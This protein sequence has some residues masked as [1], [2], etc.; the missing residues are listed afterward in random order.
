MLVPVLQR[1]EGHRLE[2]SWSLNGFFVSF[3]FAT[4]WTEHIAENIL[5]LLKSHTQLQRFSFSNINV[6]NCKINSVT[7]LS[8]LVFMYIDSTSL[9]MLVTSNNLL[10]KTLFLFRQ[11]PTSV[12][13]LTIFYNKIVGFSYRSVLLD[14]YD[15]LT[16]P[17]M[18]EIVVTGC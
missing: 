16:R 6:N 12:I 1:S 9:L 18:D 13:P 3:Y 15:L 17:I 5:Q 7:I 14:K 8:V 10:I 4:T 2:F 11:H